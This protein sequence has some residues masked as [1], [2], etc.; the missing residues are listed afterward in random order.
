LRDG[1]RYLLRVE[2]AFGVKIQARE[3]GFT[4]EGGNLDGHRM[5]SSVLKEMVRIAEGAQGDLDG[6]VVDLLVR[7]QL[8]AKAPSNLGRP[9]LY[10][11]R[12]QAV[13]A[14]T[15]GQ[16]HLVEAARKH[17]LVF[18][19]G[20]AGTGKTYLAIAMAVA[21]LQRREID[22]IVLV[23]PAVEAGEELGFLPGDLNEKI[24]PYLQ[25]MTDALQELLPRARYKECLETGL[26]EMAPLAYMRGRTLKR[27][28]AILDEAQ[29]ATIPQMRMF[30]TRIGIGSRAIVTGDP[31]QVDLHPSSKS[32]FEDACQILANVRGIAQIRLQSK[33]QMRHPLVQAIID[34]YDSRSATQ[35]V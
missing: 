11:A 24:A 10:D 33:D 12:G 4:I 18:A 20:P 29:N 34:A 13:Q 35:G 30:L 1:E 25:P 19:I 6:Y 15:E 31:T 26:I 5:A 14:R 21:A 8:E 27:C 16:H 3:P 32:G 28:F 23:R 2:N 9:I 7:D 22:R 17:E